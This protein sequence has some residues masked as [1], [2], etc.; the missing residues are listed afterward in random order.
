MTAA[1]VRVAA[2]VIL[3]P[4]GDV[5]LAQRPRG[6]AYEGYWEFPGG[7]LEPGE[8][9]RAALDRELHEEL[10]L[11]VVRASPWIVQRYVYP[12]AH[13][14]LHFFRVFEWRGEPHGRDN[15]AFA[16]QTPGQ[17]DVEPLLPAN[18]P[19]LRALRLPALYGITMAGDMGEDVFLAR[20]EA[21]L[22]GGLTLVQF[23]EKD[24]D[25]ARQRTLCAALVALADARGARVLLNGSA[26]N[27]R[28]WRCA[29]VHWTELL[30]QRFQH[31]MPDVAARV[32]VLPFLSLDAFL[33][34]LATADAVLDTPHFSGGT[35]TYEAFALGIPI[36]AWNGEFARGRQTAALYRK[37][38]ITDLIAQSADRYVDLALCLAQDKGWRAQ[39]HAELMQRHEVLYDNDAAIGELGRFLDEA[40]AAASQGRKVPEWPLRGDSGAI[41]AA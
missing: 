20:A 34:F 10:G 37:M 12:H 38:G 25:E 1:I 27:A 36:V 2:A 18:T 24:W 39:R 15:Q 33:G 9:P 11:T 16:W 6:K 19:V 17:F 30:L 40:V 23:R 28:A 31:S 32:V 3:R 35:S 21:A 26:E 7:K 41:A 5:L 4:N 22:A 8:T 13:V 29:G 14:E